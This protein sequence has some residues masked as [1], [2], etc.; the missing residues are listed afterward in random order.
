MALDL[1]ILLRSVDPLNRRMVT[2]VAQGMA[3]VRANVLFDEPW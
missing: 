2:A 3:S 1:L